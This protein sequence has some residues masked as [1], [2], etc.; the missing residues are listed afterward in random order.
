MVANHQRTQ[1]LV[2]NTVEESGKEKQSPKE[3]RK[4]AHF[5][6]DFNVVS[7]SISFIIALQLKS[8]M[9]ELITYIMKIMNIKEENLVTIFITLIITLVLC[10]LFVQYIFYDFIYT[11]DVEKEN[12]LK[13]AIQEKKA[14]VA[15]DK[16]EEQPEI[17]KKIS[18]TTNLIIND[19]ENIYNNGKYFK[20]SYGIF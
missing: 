18:E 13:T 17:Q 3:A 16:V 6:L 7:T 9:D 14:E 5:L 20:S 2:V 4:F 11:E 15:K 19:E 10:Y 1:D 8:F 12:I